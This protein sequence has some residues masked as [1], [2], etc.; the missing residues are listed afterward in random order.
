[1]QAMQALK[2]SSI[3][4]MLWNKFALKASI[5]SIGW[6]QKK[7]VW[8]C[9]GCMYVSSHCSKW[10]YKCCDENS[11]VLK[12]VHVPAKIQTIRR[13]KVLWKVKFNLNPGKLQPFGLERESCSEFFYRRVSQVCSIQAWVVLQVKFSRMGRKLMLSIYVSGIP[14]F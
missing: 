1:M 9:L 3:K 2:T 7:S 12:L 13:C 8:I 6:L 14:C 10:Q 5:T 11:H 4:N